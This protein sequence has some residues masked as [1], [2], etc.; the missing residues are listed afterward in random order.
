MTQIVLEIP[1]HQDVELLLTLFQR[2]NIKVVQWNDKKPEA[3]SDEEDLALI[4]AGLP[5]KQDFEA[6]AQ[7]FESSR[8]DK[9]M[10]SRED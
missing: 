2:L 4:A 9:P 5:P 8:K 1:R 3:K 6:Y 7:E 10:P